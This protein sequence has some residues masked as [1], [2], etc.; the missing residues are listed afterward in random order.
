LQKS[1]R[2]RITHE[3]SFVIGDGMHFVTINLDPTHENSSVEVL[4]QPKFKNITQ[5]SMPTSLLR[6][7]TKRKKNYR[8]FTPMHWNQADIGSHFLWKREGIFDLNSHM[9]LN[10]FG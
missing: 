8:G 3:N 2:S 10:F 1:Y 9:L 7:L 5:I 6:N 4:S